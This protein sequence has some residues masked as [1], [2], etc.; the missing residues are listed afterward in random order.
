[1]PPLSQSILPHRTLPPQHVWSWED[2]TAGAWAGIISPPLWHTSPD[3]DPKYTA[4]CTC[5]R[6]ASHNVH[7]LASWWGWLQE[8]GPGDRKAGDWGL[9]AN[10]WALDFS[11][12]CC[13]LTTALLLWCTGPEDED[14][15]TMD[16]D[17]WKHG[18]KNSL[19]LLTLPKA[20]RYSTDCWLTQH[21]KEGGKR[22]TKDLL[23]YLNINK[24][25][26][27]RPSSCQTGP[28]PA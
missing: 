23:F 12:A 15:A 19:T 2:M 1:M 5:S 9:R 18:L 4:K 11:L 7:V 20:S 13:S 27:L 22:E 21:R 28:Q 17:F 6:P 16:W 25:Y 3:L 26:I 14:K 24:F 10:A 8:A